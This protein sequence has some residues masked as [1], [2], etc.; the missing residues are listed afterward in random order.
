M[1]FNAV[2]FDFDGVL[3]ETTHVKTWAFGKLYAE[4]GERVAQQVIEYHLS[5]AGI[6]RFV[7]FKVWQEEFLGLPYTQADGER[8]SL[9]FSRLVVD[10]VVAAPYVPGAKEFLETYYQKLPLYI[11]SG[12]P[13]AEMQEIVHKRNMAHFFKA[14][15]GAP[16]TKGEI[17]EEVVRSGGYNPDRV[18]MVGDA[19]A[20]LQ[21]AQE[22]G[23][24]FVGRVGHE[25]KVS[26]PEGTFLIDDI[27]SLVNVM[28]GCQ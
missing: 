2:V 20:D 21:G 28:M 16:A 26:F 8:L 5:H 13:E 22:A 11:A 14:V 7:K 23:V 3:V 25:G 12:T 9:E 19:L 18:L 10:A 15:R 1:K 24:S 4:H 6:S 27:F 17:L